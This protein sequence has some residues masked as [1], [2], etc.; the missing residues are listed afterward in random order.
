ME[1]QDAAKKLAEL[2]HTTRLAIYRLLVK[3]GP[4]GLAV[5]DIQQ[6]LD[7]P[8]STLSHHISRLVNAGLMSQ[9]RQGRVLRCEA[10]FPALSALVGYLAEECCVEQQGCCD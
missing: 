6:A 3:A 4:E 2:G 8:G 1:H 5:S 7:V 10:C 9:E